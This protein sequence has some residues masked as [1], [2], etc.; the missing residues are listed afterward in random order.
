MP[1]TDTGLVVAQHRICDI[2]YGF[3]TSRAVAPQLQKHWCM[4][5]GSMRSFSFPLCDFRKTQQTW[6]QSR[7][8][9]RNHRG[10]CSSSGQACTLGGAV[11]CQVQRQRVFVRL[12]PDQL[13]TMDAPKTI[14]HVLQEISCIHACVHAKLQTAGMLGPR[15]QV[16]SS[17]ART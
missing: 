4:T 9:L 15:F 10:S 11:G 7:G 13:S 1:C 12:P 14:S 6:L 3:N 8:R 2:L 5:V 17:S 16:R